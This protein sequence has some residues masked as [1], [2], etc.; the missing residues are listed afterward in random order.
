MPQV[1]VGASA[2]VHAPPAT[3]FGI[4]ADYH[5]GHPHILP[6]PPF[7]EL[8]VERGGTGP[9]TVFRVQTRQGMKMRTF[10]M[11]VTEPEPGRLLKEQDLESDLFSTFRVDPAEGGHCRVTIT[12]Q[13]MRGGVQGGLERLLLPVLAAPVYKQEIANLERL[14]RE[15]SGG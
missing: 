9:G 6:R 11:A 14:A 5:D 1:T 4:L 8:V 2:L 13:W 12:T 10:R 3:V 7:G 15:R